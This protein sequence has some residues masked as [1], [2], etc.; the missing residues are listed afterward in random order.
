MSSA[1]YI[2]LG[3]MVKLGNNIKRFRFEKGEISQQTLADGV[4]VSRVTINSIENG[5]FVPSTILALKIAQFFDSIVEEV[6]Y[7]ID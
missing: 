4:G 5:K 1:L 6:F 3:N 7:F 2:D